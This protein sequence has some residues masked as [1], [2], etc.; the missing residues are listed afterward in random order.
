MFVRLINRNRVI[1]LMPYME[2][3]C[4]L[5]DNNEINAYTQK[6]LNESKKEFRI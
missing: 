3:F 1:K 5:G 2:V 4:K 6:G